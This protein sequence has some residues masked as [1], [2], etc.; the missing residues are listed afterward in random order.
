MDLHARADHLAQL[1]EERLDI[2]G[3][4]LATKVRRAGRRIPRW[5]HR[6]LAALVEALDRVDHPK[7]AAQVDYGRIETG[8]K[9]A[10]GWLEAV[11]PWDR[12]KSVVIH[13]LAG[14][15][16]NIM[17]VIAIALALMGWRGLL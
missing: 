6:E 4:D 10:E 7:L 3:P 9:R 1:M 14:N 11:D 16:L 12:R 15:A 5:V 13:W 17:I 2:R 8:T